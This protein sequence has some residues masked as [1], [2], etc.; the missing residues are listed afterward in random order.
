MGR[1]LVISDIHG[2]YEEFN[3][4]LELVHFNKNED[5]LLLLG[6]YVDRGMQSKE[7]VERVW[8]LVQGG[9]VVALRGNHDQ[10]FLDLMTSED[11]VVKMKFIQHGGL[12]TLESYCG[13][14]LLES[15][16]IEERLQYA[17][18][19]INKR[20][21]H[22]ISFLNSLP[23]FYEDSDHIY[24]HA[25]LNPS[26][27]N[28]KQ[29]SEHDFM[30]IKE[31]FFKNP[32]VV[33]KIVVFGHSKVIDIHE[34]ADVWFAEDKIGIDGGCAYGFQLNCLEIKDG[35]YKTHFTLANYSK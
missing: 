6:D 27:E 2:C 23:F 12:Q 35:N 15:M 22:H 3:T 13:D 20:Y 16:S 19:Y 7:V 5:L 33:D 10:R 17:V 32:T 25:G 1:T 26:Y 21:K 9:N 14:S 24:V 18:A 28:W 34:K 4:L 11:E 30:Y 31:P 8:Q 29:Q